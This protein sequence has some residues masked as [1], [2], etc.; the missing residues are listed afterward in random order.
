MSQAQ[1]FFSH[2]EGWVPD[3]TGADLGGVPELSA[4]LADG[5]RAGGAGPAISDDEDTLTYPE[6]D[7][8]AA[9]VQ[10][11][12]RAAGVRPGD[13]VVIHCRLG[14]WAIVAM[15]GVLRTGAQYVPVD[16]NFPYERRARVIA[17]S[18]ARVALVE[19]EAAGEPLP[20]DPAV[21]RILPVSADPGR[22]PDR[23]APA[24]DRDPR[25]PVYTLF[26]SGS[27]GTPKGVVVSR[28]GLACSTQ[29]RRVYF[30]GQDPAVYLL[31]TSISFDMSVGPIYHALA[32]GGHLV[33]PTPVV[34]DTEAILDACADHGGTFISIIPSLYRV[35]IDS[36]RSEDLAT[37]RVVIV[38]GEPCPPA[39]VRD[40]AAVLPRARLHNE[41]GPTEC[42]VWTTMHRCRPSDADAP[43]VPI[44]V[45]GP[46]TTAYVRT[47]G[48]PAPAG[49]RGELWLGGPQVALGYSTAT[50]D[51]DAVTDL[52]N[53]LYRTGDHVWYDDEGLLHYAGRID[54]QLKLGGLRIEL[55]EIENTLSAALG[56]RWCAVGVARR[57]GI[58]AAL[59]G[60]V[61]GGLGDVSAD[62]VRARMRESLAHAAVPGA[63]SALERMPTLANGKLDRH[64]LDRMAAEIAGIVAGVAR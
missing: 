49:V 25:Q 13:T 54:G 11:D 53:R 28:H 30:G 5:V 56:G 38:A 2:P 1:A 10:R 16:T 15:L 52:E 64:T 14:R 17:G 37:L 47:P 4:L 9:A 58:P 6:L 26:T 20:G 3:L 59:V 27:S 18:H 21:E 57:D 8:A 43:D 40:H 22:W 24:E 12:L 55:Q 36:G 34:V 44:G 39:L 62:H 41:Y 7:R 32:T 48:G 23:P 63:F 51:G 60:F 31:C 61:I 29:A 45:P 50:N 42:T 33:I 19:P 35:L 46:G